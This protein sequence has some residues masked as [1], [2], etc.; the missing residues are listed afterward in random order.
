MGSDMSTKSLS[1]LHIVFSIVR[2]HDRE[3]FLD[4]IER[5]G[6]TVGSRIPKQLEVEGDIIALR[7]LVIEFQRSDSLSTDDRDSIHEL[8]IQ[9]RRERSTR[10]HRLESDPDLDRK[11]AE[12]LAESVIGIDRSLAA[13]RGIKADED[14]E[15][16]IQRQTVADSERW[17]RF[18]K[19][20][21]T[22][23][24]DRSLSR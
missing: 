2:R 24:L 11:T 8:T 1:T 5:E 16:T 21:R 20:A 3:A 23:D 22:S 7:D 9:L 17:Q 4:R 15:S 14:I 19:K 6:A 13:L 10:R 12:Q 18:L